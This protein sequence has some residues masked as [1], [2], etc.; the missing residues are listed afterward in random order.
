MFRDTTREPESTKV[1]PKTGT[2]N[3]GF[4]NLG[5]NSEKD[6]QEIISTWCSSGGSESLTDREN[7]EDSDSTESPGKKS[8]EEK[9]AVAGSVSSDSFEDSAE[10]EAE[11]INLK[12]FKA[13]NS[14]IF[15]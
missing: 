15:F 10:S 12:D 14:M 11:V 1:S 3:P 5:F 2:E 4:S 7:S 8:A 9:N 6:M 13:R